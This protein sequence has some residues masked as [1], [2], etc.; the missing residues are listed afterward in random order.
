[1]SIDSIVQNIIES[2]IEYIMEN[3]QGNSNNL[4]TKKKVISFFKTLSEFDRKNIADEDSGGGFSKEQIEIKTKSGKK[5]VDV[6]IGLSLKMI[7]NDETEE[8]K[9][10]SGIDVRSLYYNIIDDDG[11][12]DWT[13]IGLVFYEDSEQQSCEIIE[14]GIIN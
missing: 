10:V 9:F 4:N 8:I 1:M 3:Q 2:I 11:D 6:L 5:M 13:R 14:K 12:D 7:E